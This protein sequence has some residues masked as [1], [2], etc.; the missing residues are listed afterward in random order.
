MLAVTLLAGLFVLAVDAKVLH[1]VVQEV[2][3]RI[4]AAALLHTMGSA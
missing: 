1:D 2:M 3:T 4:P